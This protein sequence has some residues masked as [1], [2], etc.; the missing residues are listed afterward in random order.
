MMRIAEVAILLTDFQSARNGAQSA[1]DESS[2]ESDRFIDIKVASTRVSACASCER[3][4][5]APARLRRCA[6]C[7]DVAYCSKEC[8]QR[9]WRYH[10]FRCSFR[11]LNAAD[12]LL[13]SCLETELPQD[14]SVAKVFKI[15]NF[16]LPT[17]R[18]SLFL[19]YKNMLGSLEVSA[20]R[21]NKWQVKACLAEGII[22]YYTKK[23]IEELQRWQHEGKLSSNIIRSYRSLPSCWDI[24]SGDCFEWFLRNLCEFC[25]DEPSWTWGQK[26]SQWI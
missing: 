9:H 12:N 16:F 20:V 7:H 1:L 2:A 3:T 11:A 8:Q 24:S 19:L 26:R 13:L 6:A 23:S 22:E 10:K 14:Q 17:D 18:Q 15:T 25:R 5:V 21:L 4:S